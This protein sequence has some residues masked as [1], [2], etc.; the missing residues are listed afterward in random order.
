MV[1]KNALTIDTLDKSLRRSLARLY[2]KGEELPPVLAQAQQLQGYYD[3]IQN[4]QGTP[5]AKLKQL[6]ARLEEYIEQ[7][8]Q[9]TNGPI[10]LARYFTL[11]GN[12][13]KSKELLEEVLEKHPD[14]LSANLAL[15]SLLQKAEDTQEAK[16][17]LQ[18][19]LFYYPENQTAKNRLKRLEK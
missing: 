15:A 3:Q 2:D 10:L 14:D 1:Y 13:I 9:D 5:R 8:P 11:T 16:R 4:L 7:Y 19:V 17:Y 12:D 18:N 6:R